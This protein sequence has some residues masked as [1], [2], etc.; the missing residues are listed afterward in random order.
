[1][2]Q[3]DERPDENLGTHLISEAPPPPLLD[4]KAALERIRQAE[5]ELFQRQM[6][7]AGGAERWLQRA[8]PRSFALVSAMI[9]QESLGNTVESETQSFW[10][11]TETRLS[12]C[13]RCPETGGACAGSSDRISAGR[14]VELRYQQ[15]GIEAIETSCDRY[16]DYRLASRLEAAGVDKRFSRVKLTQLGAPAHVVAEFDRV[17]DGV[18]SREGV[19]LIIEDKHAR[20]Y[21]VALLRTI[22]RNCPNAALRSVHIATLIRDCKDAMRMK[23][24]PPLDALRSIDVVLLDGADAELVAANARQKDALNW[25]AGEMRWLY[26]R[27]RDQKLTTIVTSTYPVREVFPGARVLRV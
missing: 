27:R 16:I 11:G 19:S 7:D 12:E 17:I 15:G 26:E 14:L 24:E 2:D 1:V 22:A 5:L 6:T 23:A 4:L 21:G 3:E 10:I 25:G 20:A 9:E 13:A 8:C 18:R